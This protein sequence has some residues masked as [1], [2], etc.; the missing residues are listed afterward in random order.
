MQW[1]N[2]QGARQVSCTAEGVTACPVGFRILVVNS[3]DV[4]TWGL[5]LDGQLALLRNLTL[6][7][8][9]GLTDYKL[10]DP[11][12]NSGPYLFPSQPS[13]SY[14]LGATYT[15]PLET[16]GDLNFNL[17]YSYVGD[18]PTHPS[19]IYDSQYILPAYGI[20]NGRATW[21][22]QD[23]KLSL[24]LF[25]NNLLD[26]TYASYASSFGGGYWDAGGPPNAAQP[27]QF[28]SR[29]AVGFTMGRPREVGV[30]LQYN[31]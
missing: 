16:A 28:P 7:F 17:S 13:P 21:R 14:T 22:S 27:A 23:R 1:S 2:R 15:V 18:Q 29:R 19:D 12:A 10:S 11:V 4:D 9:L 5:E 31:F 30:T 25:A 6:D 8:S 26:K 24:S 20:V 3:G